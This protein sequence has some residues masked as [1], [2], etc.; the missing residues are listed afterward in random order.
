MALENVSATAD[1]ARCAAQAAA[2][3]L[4]L[5]SSI[6]A[7]DPNP[8]DLY[9]K[10]KLDSER[11]ASEHAGARPDIIVVRPPMIYG[12]GMKGR[13]LKLFR[14]VWRGVPLPLA[15]VTNARSIAYAGNVAASIAYVAN[16]KYA[17]SREVVYPADAEP[18]S[19]ATLVGEIGAALGRR[20][21]L[22]RVPASVAYMIGALGSVT[23]RSLVPV[24]LDDVRR[25][26]GSL[27]V[28]PASGLAAFPRG[29]PPFTTREGIRRAAEWFRAEQA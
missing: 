13:P 5:V 27:A 3:R 9:G 17:S 18:I 1:V 29:L 20:P 21:V 24:D 12:E 23:R 15:G 22:L 16:A 10:S 25:A 11:V 14:Y 4:V 8:R 19:T 2:R 6:A 28:D 7:R 26:L